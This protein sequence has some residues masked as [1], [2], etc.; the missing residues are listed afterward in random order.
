MKS[1]KMKALMVSMAVLTGLG[2][3]AVPCMAETET[4]TETNAEDQTEDGRVYTFALTTEDLAG[5]TAHN[6]FISG[7]GA[8]ERNKVILKED[9]TYEYTKEVAIYDEDGNKNEDGVDLVYLYTGKYTEADGEVTLEIPEDCEFKE[10]WASLEEKGY[11]LSS[12]GKASE[13]DL[14][15]PKEGETYDP[16]NTFLTEYYVD[17]ANCDSPV[18]IIVDDETGEFS[19]KEVESDDD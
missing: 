18:V 4:E 7:I 1:K 16:M 19:Y 17:S 15:T 10:N 8:Q 9:G 3:M 13:G 6:G 5:K 2:T 14:V 12:E 11:L